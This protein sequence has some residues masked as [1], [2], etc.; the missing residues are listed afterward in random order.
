MMWNTTDDG[1]FWLAVDGR[2]YL[3][4]SSTV[5][6]GNAKDLCSQFPGF[7]LGVFSA[8]ESMA[9]LKEFY[10]RDGTQVSVDLSTSNVWGDGVRY[11]QTKSLYDRT[12][13][14]NYNYVMLDGTLTHKGRR[15]DVR[16]LCQADLANAEHP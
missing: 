15:E 9:A 7:R 6:A 11:D 5:K 8:L 14:S 12:F 3:T 1:S 10:D 13:V 4:F 16:L 2:L